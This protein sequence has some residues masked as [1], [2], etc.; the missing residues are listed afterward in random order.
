MSESFEI[1][2]EITVQLKDGLHM[3]PLSQI[4]RLAT[5]FS[6]PVKIHRQDYC[7][8]AKSMLDLLQLNAA[9]G[10]VLVIE[11]CGQNAEE[12]IEGIKRLVI[13]EPQRAG[14]DAGP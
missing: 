14:G 10:T 4:N 9:H 5:A 2:R 8:D 3:S 11:A 12:L 1:R 7:A 6:G 13:T